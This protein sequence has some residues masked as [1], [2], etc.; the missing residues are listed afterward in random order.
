MQIPDESSSSLYSWTDEGE[1]FVLVAFQEV[2][3]ILE[4]FNNGQKLSAGV[5]FQKNTLLA[6][7]LRKSGCSEPLVFAF[8]YVFLD[9]ADFSKFDWK[10]PTDLVSGQFLRTFWPTCHHRHQPHCPQPQSLSGSSS[11]MIRLISSSA[12]RWVERRS[13]LALLIPLQARSWFLHSVPLR[14]SRRSLGIWSELWKVRKASL[15]IQNDRTTFEKPFSI[16]RFLWSSS[17]NRRSSNP[18]GWAP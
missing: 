8:F 7:E 16:C 17:D 12:S 14:S 18:A 3:P 1:N 10:S 9:L 2:P 15:S 6:S 5:I 13:F 4:S 11:L